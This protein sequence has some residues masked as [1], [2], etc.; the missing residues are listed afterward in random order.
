[1]LFKSVTVLKSRACQRKPDGKRIE[2]VL[3][4]R[5]ARTLSQ[6]IRKNTVVTNQSKPG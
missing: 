1:M 5:Q 3:N 2:K 4:Q 6:P